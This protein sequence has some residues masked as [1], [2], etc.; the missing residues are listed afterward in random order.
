MRVFSRLGLL[1]STICKAM[2]IIDKIHP[3]HQEE[4]FSEE[5]EALIEKCLELAEITPE[6]KELLDIFALLRQAMIA[7]VPSRNKLR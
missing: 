5:I 4:R 1:A 2:S 3:D 6:K 7:K